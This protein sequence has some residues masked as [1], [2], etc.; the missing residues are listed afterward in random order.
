MPAVPATRAIIA[1]IVDQMI[2]VAI[3]IGMMLR[4]GQDRY[5][6]TTL[7]ALMAAMAAVADVVEESISLSIGSRRKR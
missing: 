2:A 1:L 4:L 3:I 5:D 6:R 7:L